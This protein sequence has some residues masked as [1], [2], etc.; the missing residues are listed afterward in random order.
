[1]HSI[2]YLPPHNIEAEEAIL[3]GILLDPNAIARIADL[4]VPEA[5]YISA[6]AEIYRVAI[7]LHRQGKP[8]DLMMVTS[9]LSDRGK[10]DSIGGTGKIA[11][12][13]DRTVSAVNIDRYAALAMEKY[14]RRYLLQQAQ[15]IEGTAC[16]TSRDL[17]EVIDEAE[18]RIFAV[19]RQR[20]TQEV[21]PVSEV[22]VRNFE[23]IEKYASGL[24][25]PGLNTGLREIDR[26]AGGLQRQDLIVIGGRPSTGKTA[27]STNLAYNIALL[28]RLPV[29]IFS[30][31]MSKEQLTYR[32]LSPL[33]RIECERL[34][35]GRIAPGELAPL[36][37]AIGELSDLPIFIDDTA[38]PPLLDI[39]AKVRRVAARSR[40]LG[41]ILID[42][43]QLMGS[44]GTSNRVIELDRIT[45]NLKQLAKDFNVPVL[46]LS[47]LHRGVESRQDKRP[48]MSDLRESGGIEQAADLIALLYREDYYNPDS[49]ERGI[50]EVNFAKNRNGPTGVVK[51]LFEKEYS[52]F[53]DLYYR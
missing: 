14:L 2:D 36:S 52:R 16:D 53:L 12:L 28:H 40:Q 11:Q 23:E 21:E 39:R 50:V 25:Q 34:K 46:C 51:L 44:E 24:F 26:L 48:L 22:L 33:A 35:A 8:T 18:Q 7:A 19:A 45:R 31:E 47:Q 1:M 9:A 29:I 13:V 41:L 4:L 43:L 30:L 32:L 38:N 37:R 42:Y 17:E 20:P 5:F 27:L 10:L 15:E 6:H 49:P 3:G